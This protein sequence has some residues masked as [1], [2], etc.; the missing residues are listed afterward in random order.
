MSEET[1]TKKDTIFTPK[2]TVKFFIVTAISNA[3][4]AMIIWPIMELLFSKI[5]NSEYTWGLVNGIVEPVIF[6]VVFAIIEFIC[7]DF[8]YKKK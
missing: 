2:K 7:W 8:F 3:I 6:G 1:K 5:D 4:A